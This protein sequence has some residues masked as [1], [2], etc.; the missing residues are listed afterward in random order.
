MGR[1]QNAGFTDGEPWLPLSSDIA[2]VNVETQRGDTRSMFSLY[3]ALIAL[4]RR[5]PALSVG[6]HV[7]AEAIGGVLTYRRFHAGRWITVALNFVG[8]AQRSQAA[9]RKCRIVL[10]THLDRAERAIGR[11]RAA[12]CERRNCAGRGMIASRCQKSKETTRGPVATPAGHI[13]LPTHREVMA[14]AYRMSALGIAPRGDSPGSRALAACLHSTPPRVLF[15]TIRKLALHSDSWRAA[16]RNSP[17]TLCALQHP[18][19]HEGHSDPRRH[20][21]RHREAAEQRADLD[22]LAGGGFAPNR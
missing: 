20:Q 18:I 11:E 10:S 7:K 5:E 6:V 19:A 3:R 4:R 15:D 1:S 2:T 8:S 13:L 22:C 16:I 14:A 21:E 17:L 12:A 9:E